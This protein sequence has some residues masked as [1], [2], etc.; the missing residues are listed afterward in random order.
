MESIKTYTRDEVADAVKNYFNN[1]SDGSLIHKLAEGRH[2]E[3]GEDYRTALHHILRVTENADTFPRSTTPARRKLDELLG[4]RERTK[5]LGGAAIDRLARQI[6][7][8]V[9]TNNPIEQYRAA[10]SQIAKKFPNLWRASRDG[11]LA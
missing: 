9:H 2:R 7:T 8:N 11:Y 6:I 10:L 4:D 1:R 3:T 5:Y